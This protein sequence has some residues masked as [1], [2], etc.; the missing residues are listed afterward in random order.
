MGNGVPNLMDYR[1][2][3]GGNLSLAAPS[4]HVQFL[5]IVRPLPCLR[6]R[7]AGNRRAAGSARRPVTESCGKDV[8]YR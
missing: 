1:E 2:E 3:S 7:T 8:H 4:A 6:L 5:L